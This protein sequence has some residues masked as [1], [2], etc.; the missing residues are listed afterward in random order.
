M[1]GLQ[2]FAGLPIYR[3]LRNVISAT[4]ALSTLT[5]SL[6][7]SFLA[8]LVSDNSRNLEKI[9][10]GHFPPQPPTKEQFL[11]GVRVLVHGYLRVRFDFPCSTNVRDINAFPKLWLKTFIRP[12]Y[13]RVSRVVPLRSTAVISN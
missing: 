1:C 6:N 10:L 13:P 12:G 4:L 5:S 3:L 2:I 8:R 11:H 7:M 9:E